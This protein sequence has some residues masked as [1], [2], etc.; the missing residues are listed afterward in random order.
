MSTL[1]NL[2]TLRRLHRAVCTNLT[3]LPA[4]CYPHRPLVLAHR[5]ARTRRAE[6]TLGAF[7]LG[8]EQGA[9][10]VELDVQLSRDRKVLVFHDDTLAKLGHA[11]LALADLTARELM[12]FNVGSLVKGGPPERDARMPLLEDVLG[13]LPSHAVINVELKGDDRRDDG[14]EVEVLRAVARTRTERRV[15]FSSFNPLRCIRLRHLAP[16]MGVGQ[17]HESESAA[18]LRDL[19]WLPAIRPHALHPGQDLVDEAYMEHARALGLPVNVWTVNEPAQML[20]L[21]ALGVSA[22]ITDV[23]DVALQVLGRV[24][25]GRRELPH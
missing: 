5:G 14:L 13:T 6:N 22:L 18:H 12:E 8:M 15:F 23:P 7:M 2:R 17:L 25:G 21:V 1:R 11:H 19:W 24:R 20:R 16:D 3:P 9:D 4:S 10:G